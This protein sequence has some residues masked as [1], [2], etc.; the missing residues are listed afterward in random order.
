MF[1]QIISLENLLTAWYEFRNGKRSKPD[2]Q[3]FEYTLEDN[4][5]QLHRELVAGTYQHTSYHQFRLSDPK[6]RI[7]SK[8]TVRDRIL[9]KAIYRI[10]YPAFD[11]TFIYDSYSCRDYKGTHAAFLRTKQIARKVSRNY[12]GQCWALKCDVRKFFDSVDH[13]ILMGLLEE[14]IHDEKMMGLL[15]GI[16]RSFEFKPGQGMPLGNLTS[17]LFANVYLDPLDKFVKHQLKIKYYLRYADDFIFFADNPDELM[18]YFIEVARFLRTEL[19]LQVHPNK[20]ILRKL[21]WGIDF[22]GYMAFA[23][24]DLPRRKTADRIVRGLES[25]IAQEDE[26]VESRYQSYLGYLSHVDSFGRKSQ[27]AKMMGYA[28]DPAEVKK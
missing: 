28:T 21:K 22:V 17:Q 5:F 3:E 25:S 4:I 15:A 6:P 8:A 14:R 19:K 20:T 11:T 24:H 12:T 23:H 2:V 9:H 13:E 18:G 16:I 1:D 27:L 10:L 26:N 7:I